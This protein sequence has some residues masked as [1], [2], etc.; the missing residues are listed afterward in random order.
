MRA[1][2]GMGDTSYA[3]ASRDRLLEIAGDWFLTRNVS[4]W[5]NNSDFIKQERRA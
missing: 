1:S 3:K 4:A 2:S 5:M